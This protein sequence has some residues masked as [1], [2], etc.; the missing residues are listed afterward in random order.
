MAKCNGKHIPVCVYSQYSTI[1]LLFFLIPVI[2]AFHTSGNSAIPAGCPAD[3]VRSH[4]LRAQTYKLLSYANFRFQSRFRLST[5]ACD[6]LAVDQRF[7]QPPVG[8]SKFASGSQNSGK[9]FTFWI[10]EL[11]EKSKTQEQLGERHA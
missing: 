11:L 6:Q 1:T 5:C 10:T 4:R 2:W 3:S 8:F 9:R 7:S